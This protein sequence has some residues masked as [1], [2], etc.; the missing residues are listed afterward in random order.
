MVVYTYTT[1]GIMAGLYVIKEPDFMVSPAYNAAY[2]AAGLRFHFP[3]HGLTVNH[4]G[5]VE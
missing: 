5:F 4:K 1:V 2:Y 3:K